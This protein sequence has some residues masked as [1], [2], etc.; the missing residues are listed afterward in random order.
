MSKNSIKRRKGCT[1]L[2]KRRKKRG[3]IRTVVR[4]KKKQKEHERKQNTMKWKELLS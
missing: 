2:K 4:T 3:R 1:K